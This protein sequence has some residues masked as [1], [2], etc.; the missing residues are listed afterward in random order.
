MVNIDKEKV[1]NNINEAY[2]NQTDKVKELLDS[3]KRN[4]DTRF[5]ILNNIF[6][7]N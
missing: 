7:S 2:N 3:A 5:L 1:N 4:L 6:F